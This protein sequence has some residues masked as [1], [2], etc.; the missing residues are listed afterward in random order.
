MHTAYTPHIY[1]IYTCTNKRNF[2]S[3]VGYCSVNWCRSHI[4]PIFMYYLCGGL[5]VGTWWSLHAKI[6][7]KD[8][9]SCKSYKPRDG[10]IPKSF[11]V[12]C[13][14]C[15][16]VRYLFI[17]DIDIQFF[18]SVFFFCLLHH[19]LV[20]CLSADFFFLC[21]LFICFKWPVFSSLDSII[22]HLV[23]WN[24]WNLILFFFGIREKETEVI[25]WI[26]RRNQVNSCKISIWVIISMFQWC[27][28]K[29]Q[30]VCSLS[31]TF[32][33]FGFH[34]LRFSSTLQLIF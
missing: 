20:L 8:L 31:N 5:T 19:L 25:H 14:L 11:S 17:L 22:W 26:W 7:T 16:H 9:F 15:M 10:R 32:P 27:S 24:F 23:C 18:G 13:A 3:L 2:W 12:L 6:Y 4:L 30:R 29:Y 34:V 28:I 33:C 21:V 1:T